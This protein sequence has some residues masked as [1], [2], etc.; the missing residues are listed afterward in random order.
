MVSST[1]HRL[2]AVL[3]A[4]LT[5][6]G[7]AVVVLTPSAADARP[8]RCHGGYPAVVATSTRVHL[9]RS[10]GRYGDRNAA[11]VRVRS[12]AGV[13]RGR[14]TLSVAGRSSSR[15]LYGGFAF[16]VLP[17]HLRPRHTYAVTARYPGRGCFG[18]SS[19]VA[20]YTVLPRH[21]H[22]PPRHHRPHHHQPPR[23]HPG[24]H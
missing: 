10:V 5:T 8:R 14:V 22:H 21:R 20:Y 13:P 11:L 3:T 18:P 7:L 15:R 16:F 17:R 9:A 12:D 2:L 4:L 1:S 24:G 23:H 6:L 19:G